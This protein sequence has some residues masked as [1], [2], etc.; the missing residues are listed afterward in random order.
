MT[1]H[2]MVDI[3][4]RYGRMDEMSQ[5]HTQTPSGNWHWPISSTQMLCVHQKDLHKIHF[6]LHFW[7]SSWSG[8][9]LVQSAF[10]VVQS[11]L[12]FFGEWCNS[13]TKC[14]VQWTSICCWSAVQS[15][16]ECRE[17]NL[18]LRWRQ[19]GGRLSETGGRQ[20]IIRRQGAELSMI[21]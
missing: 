13:A 9:G 17:L 6:G 20:Q 18:W 11:A 14:S 15:A 5:Q 12:L 4:A 21:W 16:T 1:L 3:K 19:I 2:S 7:T 8:M 10:Y